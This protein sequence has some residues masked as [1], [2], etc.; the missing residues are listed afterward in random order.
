MRKIIAFIL[1]LA[2]FYSQLSYAIV[3]DD[4][5]PSDIKNPRI[6]LLENRT[7]ASIWFDGGSPLKYY[8]IRFMEADAFEQAVRLSQQI[9][10]CKKLTVER[11]ETSQG[12]RFQIKRVFIYF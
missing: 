3:L 11:D 6:V 2:V 9:K 7:T 4:F 1:G 8:S 12:G 10:T 5:R